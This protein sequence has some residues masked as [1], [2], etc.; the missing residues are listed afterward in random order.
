MNNEIEVFKFE[1]GKKFK[2]KDQELIFK[3]LDFATEKHKDQKRETGEPYIIHPIA[4]A[5]ILLQYGLDA[6]AISAALLHDVV[7]DTGV[8]PEELEVLFG[9]EVSELVNGVSRVK[10]LR[11]KSSAN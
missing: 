11:Y 1:I 8:T 5:T 3:A 10:T 6:R 4:V 2:L 9:S 7:E